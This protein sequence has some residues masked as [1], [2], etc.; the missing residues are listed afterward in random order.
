MVVLRGGGGFVS[1][2]L[3]LRARSLLGPGALRALKCEDRVLDGP[4]SGEKG[5]KGESYIGADS[6][7]RCARALAPQARE[8]GGLVLDWVL[9]TCRDKWTTLSA[10]GRLPTVLADEDGATVK[11]RVVHADLRVLR[12]LK[13]SEL[14]DPAPTRPPRALREHVRLSHLTAARE[15]V[16][17]SLEVGSPRQ[18]PNEHALVLVAVRGRLPLAVVDT[19]RHGAVHLL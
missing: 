6:H 15:V 10:Q 3:A 5:S 14:D 19:A 4:A 17:K 1:V 12:L 2:V 7:M 11:L 13:R 16:L 8:N 9:T 18:V